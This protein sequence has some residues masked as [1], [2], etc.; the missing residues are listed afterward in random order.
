ISNLPVHLTFFK[1]T[2]IAFSVMFT[3]LILSA[4]TAVIAV[5]EL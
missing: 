1:P 2:L 3:P 4:S 5:A